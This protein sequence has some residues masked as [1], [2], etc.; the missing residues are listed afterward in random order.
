MKV[1][2]PKLL[3]FSIAISQLAGIVGSIFT[4]AEVN[5]WYVFLEKPSFNP[6]NWIFGPV[7]ITLYTLMG[8][9]LYLI[10]KKGYKKV[11]V[12][13]AVNIFFIHLA[14]NSAWSIIFFSL[15]N[16]ALAFFVIATL[17]LFIFYLIKLFL[18][19]DRNAAY[20]LIPYL[21]W[22]SIASV[23]NYSIWMLN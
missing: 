19:I 20:L 8:I 9:S 14:I 2:N 13:F 12:K 21:F 10:L 6:P 17:W 16:L 5:N 7:W 4:T 22:V 11:N 15:H 18:K 1:D 3:I 23:L